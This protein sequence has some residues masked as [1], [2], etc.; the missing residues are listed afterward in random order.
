MNQEKKSFL[1]FSYERHFEY[2][3]TPDLEKLETW[4]RFDTIDAWRHKRMYDAVLPLIKA[5]P[6]SKWL[7]IGDGRYGTDANY[8]LRNNVQNVLATSINNTLL[9]K[10]KEEGFITEY[11]VENAESL[12]FDDNSFD[13]V[14]CKESYHHFPRPMIAFYEML[15]VAGTAVIIIEPNDVNLHLIKA[16]TTL[17]KPKNKVQLLKDFIKDLVRIK[18]YDYNNYNPDGYET[19]GNYIYSTSEREF[20]KA[21]LGLNLP[22]I[23]FKGINDYYDKGV[24]FQKTNEDSP[25]FAKIK[26][27]ISV[28]ND[29]CEKNGKPYNILVSI[30]FKI[31]PGENVFNELRNSGF[32]VDLLPRN[33]FA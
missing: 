6:L 17:V 27:A 2:D 26:K 28:M 23:A 12:S 9:K 3:K 15:R 8:L 11:K 30:I 7:T 13:F 21:A 1:H 20:E 14:F 33:P 31:M 22:A 18:R 4:K 10:S 29:D 24:E 19:V 16:S 32:R 5:Y 25:L